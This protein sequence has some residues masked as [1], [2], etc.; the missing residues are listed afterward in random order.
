MTL[1]Q[2]ARRLKHQFTTGEI[3]P[4]DLSSQAEWILAQV[5]FSPEAAREAEANVRQI[6]NAIER[7]AFTQAEPKRTATLVS[8]LDEAIAFARGR[9]SPLP[10]GA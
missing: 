10:E 2:E 6:V 8:L 3:A 1:E 9:S 5:P 7:T 4:Q